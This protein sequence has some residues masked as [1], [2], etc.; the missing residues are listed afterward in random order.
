MSITVIRLPYDG[1]QQTVSR[2]LLAV[3]RGDLALAQQL[4]E[5]TKTAT[6]TY[7]PYSV[8]KR[9][10]H[11]DVC[12][13]DDTMATAM[14]R[15]EERV[16]IVKQV[17]ISDLIDPGSDGPTIRMAFETPTAFRVTGF[18]HHLPDPFH[19]FGSLLNRWQALGWPDLAEPAWNRIPC[20]AEQTSYGSMEKARNQRRGFMGAYRYEVTTHEEGRGRETLWTL[21]RFAEYAGVGQGTTYGLGRVRIL[22]DGDVWSSGVKLAAWELIE[23]RVHA[24]ARQH[25][26]Q[27]AAAAG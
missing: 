18:D 5:P 23:R 10:H 6:A 14:L 9:P 13:F 3:G 20:W 8:V 16:S 4:H 2:V 19:V 21:A 12:V 27:P 7:R 15:G 26:G 17:R 25:A 24:A 11:L 22:R 1:R